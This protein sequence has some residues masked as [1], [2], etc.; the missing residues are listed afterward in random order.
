M[1]AA[2]YQD[3]LAAVRGPATVN[4]MLEDYRAGLTI[5]RQRDDADRAA[6]RGITIRCCMSGPFATTRPS[7]SAI[8]A[9]GWPGPTIWK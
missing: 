9:R 6:G 4:A 2:N 1:G 8:S 3:Y 7:C 5:D